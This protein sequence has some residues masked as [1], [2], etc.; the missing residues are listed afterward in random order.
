MTHIDADVVI[1]GAGPAGSTA[2]AHLAQ[3]GFEVALLEKASFPRDKICGDALTPRAVRETQR[4][5]IPT[6]AEDGWHPNRGLR[7]I[8]AGHRLEIDWPDVPGM[9]DHGLTRPRMKLDADLA[10]FAAACGARLHENTMATHPLLGPDGWV[11]GVA[12]RA[13]DERGRRTGPELTFRAPVVIA[14]DG[15]SSRMAVALGIEKRDDRPMG[16]AVRTYHS[17]PRHDDDYIESW[18]ELTAPTQ[19]T[20]SGQATAGEVMPGYGW[21]F[22]LGDGT[23]NVGLGML[24]TSPA[25]GQVDYRAVLRDWIAA[26]GHEWDIDETT[27]LTPV[28]SAALPMAFNRTPHFDRGMLLIGDAG[29]MVNPFN[30]EGI[31]YG[32]EAARI[33]AEVISTYARYPEAARRRRLAEYPAAVRDSFGSYFTLGRV[34]AELIGRPELMSLGIKYGMSSRLVMTFVVKLLANLYDD[35]STTDRDAYDYVITALTRLTP[36]TTND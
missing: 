7:L 24:N 27:E 35:G 3:A 11:T 16:V 17:S 9:P 23:V 25:F 30:G 20:V 6:R 36:A 2:A 8:G 22:P 33:A 1:V 4:L 12:A 19:T 14:A 18:V 15:V 13:T 34:F 5:G 28:R 10:G 21:L 26:M 32:M 29:G 31:D